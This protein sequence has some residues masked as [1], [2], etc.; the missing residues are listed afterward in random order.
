MPIAPGTRL[1]PYEITAPLGA[2]GMGEVFRATDTRLGREVAVRVLPQHLSDSPEVRA[3]FE[4]EAKMVSSL[5]QLT[6]ASDSMAPYR[7]RRRQDVPTATPHFRHSS[8]IGIPASARWTGSSAS[9]HPR[10]PEDFSSLPGSD[11]GENLNGKPTRNF[12]IIPRC[13]GALR[14]GSPSWR[15]RNSRGAMNPKPI[16]KLATIVSADVAGY[17]RLMGLDEEGTWAAFTAHRGE[18][19]DPL[20]ESHRGR[21]VKTAGDG[22]LIE[23]ASVVDAV[24]CCLEVQ[25]GMAERN[26]SVAAERRIRFRIGINLGDVIVDG[27]DL[28]GDGV[29]IAARLEAMA[30]PGGICISSA[31]YEQVQRK[32]RLDSEDLGRRALKNI[33]EPVHAYRI[34]GA[35]GFQR[36]AASMHAAAGSEFSL[37]G[38]PSIAILPFKNLNGD[39]ENEFISDGIALGIQTLMVQL[40]G[41]FLINAVSDPGYRDGKTTAA[42]AVRDLPIRY[43]LEG[44]SQ[45]AGSRVRVTVQLTD[46]VTNTVVWARRYDRDLED[47]FALQDD[48]T[49]EVTSSLK[50]ELYRPDLERVLTR[51]LAGDGAWEYFLRGVS[52]L[53]KF[54]ADDNLRAREMFKKL[55]AVRPDRVQGPAY[56][57]VTYWLEAVHGWTEAP[58]QAWEQASLWAEKAIEY[59]DNDGLGHVVMS[60]IRLHEGEHDEALSLC[61]KAVTYRANCPAALGQMANVQIYCGD[62]SGAVKSARESM[63]VRMIHPPTV[64]H[65][66]ATAYRDIA[67]FD[68]SIAAA[69][70]ACRLDDRYMDALVT[71]CSDY[72]LSG[73]KDEA[74][75]IARKI[76]TLDPGFRVA[77]FAA[78]QPYKHKATLSNLV[79]ALRAA[80]LPG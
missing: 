16:R 56:L 68:R 6:H 5:D 39:T 38:R 44:T 13:T 66:L 65:L 58:S 80:G 55:H 63:T 45:R 28:F 69:R 20:V 34:L 75:D 17:S 36:T 14:A 12:G 29:N 23:F 57:A 74:R 62:A 27:D 35:S 3:R 15:A 78:R 41:L 31:A 70:E 30:A 21:I 8:R 1:G 52:H 79:E 50:V 59:E 22:L 72:L 48:I 67:E 33:E 10:L 73:N 26:R 25:R 32:L 76:M 7:W 54:N 11:D 2:G 4:R 42:E 24:T 18:L 49:R 37:P 60:D 46:L 71:L 47:V 43:V 51:E 61:R 19:I 64:I 77:G 40:S 9:P 53:Y